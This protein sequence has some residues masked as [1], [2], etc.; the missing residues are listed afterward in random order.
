[1]YRDS[2]RWILPLSHDEVVHG[3]GSLLGKMPGDDW[4]RFANLRCL[5]A[6]LYTQPG[7]K[8]LF[9]GSELAPLEEWSHDRELT[10]SLAEEPMRAAFA[11]YLADLGA[12]YA[13][14]PALWAADP[15]PD[16]FAWIDATD[17][18]AGVFAYLRLDPATGRRLAVV[19]NLTPVARSPY[20]V[21][22]PVPGRWEEVL[23]SDAAAYGGSGVG[24]AGGVDALTEAWHGQPCSAEL[25]LPPL[26]V[27][28]LRPAG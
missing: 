2:E 11:G 17:T 27:V 25:S 12:L 6:D 26:G 1:M 8:L 14:E 4:Q 10:W 5:L 19:M 21:G 20:R 9:M 28:L 7:G 13:A 3:K 16:G 24:N 22:L 18:D 23:N 15:D